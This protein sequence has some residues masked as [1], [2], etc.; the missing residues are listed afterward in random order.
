MA[1]APPHP[2]LILASRSP[3]RA[4]LLAQVAVPFK[5]FAQDID[6]TPA[7]GEAPL[8]YAERMARE[9]ALAARDAM[10]S[11]A[12]LG[13]IWFLGADTAVVLDEDIMGKP[14]NEA[15][16]RGMLARLSDR[17]HRV[18]S[19]VALVPGADTGSEPRVLADVSITLVTFTALTDADLDDYL[20]SREPW[21]KAGAYGIQG[22][23]ARF[24]R[25]IEGS[26]SGVVG[27]PLF[28]T[29]R[30]LAAAGI[31]KAHQAVDS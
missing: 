29:C 16:A 20:A 26:Y 5:V 9:K 11:H 27:L 30:L 25:R 1:K 22:L 19:A 18:L 12:A 24:V 17:T 3:R 31:L 23:A 6:E 21:D 4:E 28:E 8:D 13:D 10:A 14:V 2:A 15:D 7:V